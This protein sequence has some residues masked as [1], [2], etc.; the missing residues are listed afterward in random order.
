MKTQIKTSPIHIFWI[1][2]IQ[3]L[4]AGITINAVAGFGEELGWRS[5][6]LKEL[7]YTGFWKSSIIIGFIWGVWH[8]LLVIQG[9]TYPQHPIEGLF[10]MII[11]CILFS[12]IFNYIRLKSKSVI[13][14]V[15]MH[16]SLNGTAGLPL[17]I[18]KGG[19]D[20]TVGVTGA[21]GLITLLIINF[22]ILVFNNRGIKEELYKLNLGI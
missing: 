2:L 11:F 9:H 22:T 15:I 10:M 20:L 8:A 14:T 13:T 5:F 1:T 18:I 16:G 7:A 3:G 6:L 17:L 4:L 19:N 12:P 21:A